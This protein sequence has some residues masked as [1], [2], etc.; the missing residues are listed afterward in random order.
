M[1]LACLQNET[2]GLARAGKED[3]GGNRGKDG[4]RLS[5]ERW[6]DPTAVT[7]ITPLQSHFPTL[8]LPLY[9]PYHHR[10][11]LSSPNHYGTIVTS[12]I[13]IIHTDGNYLVVCHHID[14]D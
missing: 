12:G 11:P 2:E 6:R 9:R 5:G 8:S 4:P 10:I 3:P 1:N 14:F 13:G 7:Y